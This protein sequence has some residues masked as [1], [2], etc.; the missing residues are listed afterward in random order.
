MV[1]LI[2]KSAAE[3][4]L[5]V[6]VAGVRVEEIVAPLA[7]LSPFQ[8][9][10]AALGK[11]LKKAHGVVLPK[12]GQI[13][14]A[15]EVSCHWFGLN[16]VM[17]M[18]AAPDASLAKVAAVTDQSDAWCRVRMT[19]EAAR[20]VLARLTPIDLRDAALPVGATARTDIQHMS[21]ALTRVGEDVWEVMVFRS[22]ARTLVHDLTTS[23]ETVAGIAEMRSA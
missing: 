20:D 9:Q 14:Q 2:A 7:S 23:L 21:G 15:G 10:D 19:G 16:H 11:A 3:G 22:V 12:A 18:G 13:T 4:L 1:K 17:L 5:P 8:G 6:E